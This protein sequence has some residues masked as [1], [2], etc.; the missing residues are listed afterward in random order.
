MMHRHNRTIKRTYNIMSYMCV[1]VFAIYSFLYLYLLH[2]GTIA[3][4]QHVLSDGKTT[5][6]PLLGAG[7]VTTALLILAYVTRKIVRPAMPCIALTFFQPCLLLTLLTN[8]VSIPG[9]ESKPAFVWISVILFFVWYLVL[10]F[11]KMQGQNTRMVGPTSI[12]VSAL[13]FN[14]LTFALMF[15]LCGLTSEA[16]DAF[17]YETQVENLLAE[18]NIE[19]ALKTGNK[20]EST[21]LHLTA[22][23]SYALSKE[24]TI[25]ESLFHYPQNYKSNGLLIPLRDSTVM[26]FSPD[27]LFRHVGAYPR[28]GMS[29]TDFLKRVA[30]QQPTNRV[31]S[32]YYLCALLLDKN[33]TEFVNTV[34]KYYTLNDSLPR[35]Y[36]EALLMYN[37]L[38]VNSGIE[39]TNSL[40]QTDFDDY[41]SIAAKYDDKTVRRNMLKKSFGS[42]YWWY[43]QY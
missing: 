8:I 28:K 39:Y 3:Y 25:G 30:K 38:H 42:T 43:Y 22:L 7:I 5:Y 23:R 32:D 10:Y 40:V 35:H 13:S 33:L 1:A 9:S 31:A 19:E 26:V 4:A 21:N 29:V 34:G 17:H 37:R 36:A 2:P 6:S 14:A 20:S 12:Y 11:L 16:N 41:L 27:K 15:S 24:G 18:N